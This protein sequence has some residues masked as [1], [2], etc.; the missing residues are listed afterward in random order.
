MGTSANSEDQ[1]EVSHSATFHQGLH[2]FL[3]PNKFSG[4]EMQFF[5]GK[6]YPVTPSIYTM[7]YPDFIVDVA[8]WKIPLFL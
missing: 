6:L 3:W 5:W 8:K 2:C 7:D 4:K 1:D